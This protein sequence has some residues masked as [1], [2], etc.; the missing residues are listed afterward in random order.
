MV[1]L[2]RGILHGTRLNDILNFSTFQAK[3]L[4]ESKVDSHI[5]GKEEIRP[6]MNSLRHYNELVLQ[7][8]LQ[9]HSCKCCETI[10]SHS[11]F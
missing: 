5:T 7:E 9:Y 10:L 4:I 3:H 1:V 8:N 6:L 2:S 11:N